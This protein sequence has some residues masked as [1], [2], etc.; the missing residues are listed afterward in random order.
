[1]PKYCFAEDARLTSPFDEYLR[2]DQI[3]GIVDNKTVC[4]DGLK[5][6]YVLTYD[7]NNGIIITKSSV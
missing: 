2:G 5:D 1:V 7:N 3:I 6:G 4:V